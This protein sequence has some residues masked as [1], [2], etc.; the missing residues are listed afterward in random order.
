MKI[1][2]NIYSLIISYFIIL[3][4]KVKGRERDIY[5]YVEKVTGMQIYVQRDN[6]KILMNFE[7]CDN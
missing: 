1:L 7:V 4:N 6:K 3:F 2:K 5:G